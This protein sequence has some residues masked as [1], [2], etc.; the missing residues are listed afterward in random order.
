MTQG[1]VWPASVKL[2]LLD[3]S[4]HFRST[5]HKLLTVLAR[6][7]LMIYDEEEIRSLLL[8]VCSFINGA[9]TVVKC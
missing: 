7:N 8:E 5:I 6:I 9:C 4:L 3:L 1:L 2:D